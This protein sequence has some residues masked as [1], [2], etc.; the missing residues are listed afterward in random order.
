MVVLLW[1]R[2]GPQSWS[3][4]RTEDPSHLFRLGPNPTPDRIKSRVVGGVTLLPCALFSTPDDLGPT[5]PSHL[6]GC[7][8][9]DVPLFVWCQRGGR[10]LFLST[11]RSSQC[12]PPTFLGFTIDHIRTYTHNPLWVSPDLRGQG[13]SGEWSVEGEVGREGYLCVQYDER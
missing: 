4:G 10:S 2:R 12:P 5:S 7:K 6:D 3:R 11:P 1:V 9:F 8:A 13:L